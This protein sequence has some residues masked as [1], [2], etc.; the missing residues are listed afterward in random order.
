M[1]GATILSNGE[2]VVLAV[3]DRALSPETWR[4]LSLMERAADGQPLRGI[5]DPRAFRN[6]EHRFDS[7]E[8]RGWIYNSRDAG[9]TVWQI[10]EAGRLA[11]FA[12]RDREWPGSAALEWTP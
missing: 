12:A 4:L 3:G 7:L 9:T 8:S 6:V 2:N 10:T 11:L 1:R 5:I